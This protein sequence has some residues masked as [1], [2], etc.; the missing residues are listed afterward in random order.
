MKTE[1]KKENGGRGGEEG[2]IEGIHPTTD[3]E[4]VFLRVPKRRV[5]DDEDDFCYNSPFR[6][7]VKGRSIDQSESRRRDE[8]EF[9][10]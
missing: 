4:T 3:M 8:R 9:R 5:E 6:F 10:R 7:V 1:K 2:V